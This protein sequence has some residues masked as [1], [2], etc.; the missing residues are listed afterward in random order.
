MEKNRSRNQMIEQRS[1]L[2]EMEVGRSERKAQ[3]EAGERAGDLLDQEQA[4]KRLGL[5][6]PD[7]L[8]L[9]R[10]Q[11]G[12][13]MTRTDGPIRFTVAALEE[14]KASRTGAAVP[15]PREERRGS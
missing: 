11:R 7:L 5:Q 8:A 14:W 6:L 4:A 2:T 9:I 3:R 13:E 1:D 12:P 15:W 10:A